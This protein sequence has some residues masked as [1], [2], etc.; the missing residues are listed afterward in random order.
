LFVIDIENYC[1]KA[2]LSQQ[3]VASARQSIC[4]SFR[5]TSEDLIVIGTSHSENFLSVGLVWR[6][7]RMVWSKGH[8]GAD[9]ALIEALETYRLNSFKEVVLVTGDHI[10]ADK[11]RQIS[12]TGVEVTAVSCRRSLSKK[13]SVAATNVHI[14]RDRARRE[15]AA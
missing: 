5:P 6:G 9:L 7:A 1:G 8:N 11:V 3:D 10:F 2:V 12:E 14:A 4:D 15:Q 13:L